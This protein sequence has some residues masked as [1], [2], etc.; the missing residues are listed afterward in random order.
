LRIIFQC[1]EEG[2]R[3]AYG[4]MTAG[5]V[6][7]FDYFVGTHIGFQASRKGM[8]IC[9]VSGLQATV[10]MDARFTGRSAHAGAAPQDGK[11]ALLAACAATTNV[12]AIARHSGGAT[13]VNVGR[14][15]GGQG[16]NV[17]PPEALM[18]FEVRGETNTL[19]EYMQKEALR[20]VR[21]AA[22]MWDCGC[23]IS[24]MGSCDNCVSDREITD[25]AMA[26]AQKVS[27]YDR[28]LGIM[29]FGAGEDVSHMM[30]KVQKD[31]GQATFIQVGTDRAA[32]HHNDRFDFDDDDLVPAVEVLVLLAR[33]YLG[34]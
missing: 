4:M 9:G 22:E 12:Y 28:V 30:E 32:G 33:E 26:A 10:K 18:S 11:N 21:A 20:I 31:G 27:A 1:A 24:I 8:I 14:L 17:I 23:E 2:A 5:C 6:D 16:R 13:R 19:N 34:T 29:E 15:N 25:R 7:G 3:G